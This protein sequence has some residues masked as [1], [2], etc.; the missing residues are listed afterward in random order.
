R[1]K[2][3]VLVNNMCEVFNGKLVGGRDKAII[4]TLEFARE[5]LVKRIVKHQPQVG[6]PKKERSKSKKETYV[7][8]I[9]KSGKLAIEHKTVTCDKCGSKGNSSRTCTR[10]RKSQSQTGTNRRKTRTYGEDDIGR[11]YWPKCNV[12]TTLLP[13]EH[14]PQVGKPKKERSKSKKETYV[15]KIAK[16][17]KLAIE[18]KTLTC[19]KCGS[20]G[21]SSRTCT[22]PRKSQSQTGTNKRKTR[23]SGNGVAVDDGLKKKKCPPRKKIINIDNISTFVVHV[24]LEHRVFAC[25]RYIL[26]EKVVSGDDE[27]IAR[28][29]VGYWLRK[30]ANVRGSK[31]LGNQPTTMDARRKK[32]RIIDMENPNL[33]SSKALLEKREKL[34][35]SV[36][37]SV[38]KKKSLKQLKFKEVEDHANRVTKGKISN[39]RLYKKVLQN[40]G[41]KLKASKRVDDIAAMDSCSGSKHKKQRVALDS[42]VCFGNRESA[43]ESGSTEILDIKLKVST[44]IRNHVLPYANKLRDYWHMGQ[45]AVF[46][47]GQD[48]LFKVAFFVSSL[49]DKLKEPILIIA[50]SSALSLWETEFSKWSKLIRVLIY[51]GNKDVRA[52]IRASEFYSESGSISY[53]VLL[54][55]PNDLVEDLDLLDHISW[56]LILIDECQ[57]PE[58]STHFQKIK[59]LVAHMKLLMITSE[60]LNIKQSYQNI[61]S[62]LHP[63]YEE[64]DTDADMQTNV[65][66]DAL[67]KKLSPFIAFECK[68]DTLK[69]EEYWVPVHLSSMQIEQYCSLLGSNMEALSSSLRNN[70]SL[71][72][73]LTRTQKCCDH[74]YLVDP[75]LRNSPK[76]D[77]SVDPLDADIY[78]SGKLQVLDKL[79]LE[80]KRCGLRVL[81]LY[82]PV[83]NSEKISTGDILDDLMDRR[84]GQDSYVRIEKI[85]RNACE[86][87]KE[88]LE[89]FNNKDSKKFVCLL[90]HRACHSSIRLSHVD[91][92]ILFNSDWN[93]LND[94]K[95]LQKITIDSRHGPLKV[96][97]L[98]SSFTI[99]EKT[100]IFSKQGTNLDSNISWS[101]CQ[102]LLAWGASYLFRKFRSYTDSEA[103]VS[104]KSLIDDLVLSLSSL[105]QN[106]IGDARSTHCSIISYAQMHDGGYSRDLLLFGEKEAHAKEGGSFDE[107]FMGGGPS[108]FWTNLIKENQQRPKNSCSR[109]SRRIQKSPQNSCYVFEGREADKPKKTSPPSKT[110]SAK[111]RKLAGASKD[112]DGH[113]SSDMLSPAPSKSKKGDA[114][115]WKYFDV[116]FVPDED[117]VITKMAYCKWCPAVYKA[118]SVKSGTANLNKHYKDCDANP[119]NEHGIQSESALFNVP[120]EYNHAVMPLT[121]PNNAVMQHA[122][123]STCLSD[124]VASSSRTN[125]VQKCRKNQPPPT[126]SY[127]PLETEIDKIQKE[128]EQITKLHQEKHGIQG[129]SALFNVHVEYNHGITQLMRSNH[130]ATQPAEPSIC[131]SDSVASSLRTSDVQKCPNNQPP[132]T[133]SKKPLETEIDKIQKEREQITKLH[134]QKKSMLLS[135]CEKIISEVRMK[136]DALV[137]ESSMCFTK[138]IKIL[139]ENLKFVDANK[140]LAEM[141]EQNTRDTLNLETIQKETSSVGHFQIPERRLE[142]P[143]NI[144]STNVA[145]THNS[146]SVGHFQIPECRLERP[147]NI[148]STN[149]AT[150]HNSGHKIKR[151]GVRAPAPHLSVAECN[152]ELN[153]IH[154]MS[155]VWLQLCNSQSNGLYQ[156]EP[157]A[158]LWDI[159]EAKYMAEDASSKKFLVSNFT[160]YKM[161]DSRP[162]LEQQYNELLG[163]LGR[164]TQHKMNMNESIKVSCIIDKLLISWKDFKHTLK[165]LKEEL[166]L[167]E[168]GSHLLI[169]ES[170]RA[171]DNDKLKG[172][173]VAGLSVVN[174]VEHNNSF[175]YNDHKGKRKH[176]DTR[177]NP[178]KKP[179]VTC[180]KC[181]KPEHLKKDCKGGNVGNRA[182]G[183]STKG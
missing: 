24:R 46:F 117:G 175:R 2:S 13:P 16:S 29:V 118:D 1:C 174:M 36:D 31:W 18:H 11:L 89:M 153:G 9:A 65:D 91:V 39:G 15:V 107:F 164:F 158:E 41:Q 129:E 76:K 124:S 84:F 73:I 138:Q 70:S 25:E 7:V 167:V 50:D 152:S 157:S 93:P 160:N 86:K 173:N 181:G 100:L 51:K 79:L 105:L 74:P 53:Q 27:I 108:V 44:E 120:V 34:F 33:Y 42:G 5:Y 83:I 130:A 54:S 116:R 6:K 161:T 144:C 114:E 109:T 143:A 172:N 95:N 30:K 145:T 81:I 59:I 26:V 178:N 110:K 150:T 88:A 127:K 85:F 66:T 98:Y 180:W 169:E 182:N 17:G 137:H 177:A 47:D 168:L 101:N 135:E 45:N 3:D 22:R 102:Q 125:D 111:K 77:A 14:Q 78:V 10:P 131:I 69:C 151:T 87:K 82:Q 163:I 97:R 162:V 67:K 159:L 134:E 133:S 104:E 64:I 63:K 62:L 75:T 136:Y 68:F 149:V 176:Q 140:L 20:K 147:A 23:T 12:P 80:I 115:C 72:D 139:E 90:D 37:M 128:R 56:G 61:L 170:L 58:I 49:L 40:A 4:S 35:A 141:L 126:S 92:A 148:C 28:K 183:S 52:D 8:K 99:E 146:S 154:Q 123:P 71:N 132:P 112:V 179:E 48:R 171:Q 94:R 119:A 155:P 142:R 96:L 165:H 38:K 166:T 21:N 60:T 19:D 103:P 57:R 156:I 121:R 55:S 113:Q 32:P 122:K 106:K 43:Y